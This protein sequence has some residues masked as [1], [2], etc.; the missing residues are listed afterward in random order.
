MIPA[1]S[2]GNI[3]LIIGTPN[4]TVFV[5]PQIISGTA[6]F[7]SNLKRK[8]TPNAIPVI[9]TKIKQH[10]ENTMNSDIGVIYNNIATIQLELQ[11]WKMY[12]RIHSKEEL[13]ESRN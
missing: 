2:A 13:R 1:M 3:T 7:L 4:A 12:L 10:T 8:E 11:Y 9:T 5:T 6:S